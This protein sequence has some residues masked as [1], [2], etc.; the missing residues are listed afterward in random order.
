MAKV[1]KGGRKR[2]TGDRFACGR[3][4]PLFD[5]G[6]DRTIESRR[7]FASFHGGRGDQQT[8]DP[9]GRAW[10]VGLLENERIDPAVLREAGRNYAAAYWAY[11]EG[12]AAIVAYQVKLPRS[13][14]PTGATHDPRGER[15]RRLDS[16]LK[17]AGRA[18][19]DAAQ[20]LC[21]DPYFFPDD[22]PLWLKR[23]IDER[24]PV[25][26]HAATGSLPS[27]ADRK[28]LADAV[29]GLLALA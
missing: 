8:F 18:A 23:L 1:R 15:F 7:R 16:A 11:Y 3:L 19:Y 6:S 14:A 12:G 13:S 21:V 27:D 17:D 4:R 10:C 24:L 20:S 29:A 5:R 25:G 28:R 22:D 2:R 26:R 9:I